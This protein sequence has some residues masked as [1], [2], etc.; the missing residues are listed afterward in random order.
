MPD[1]IHTAEYEQGTG[2]NKI[3]VRVYFDLENKEYKVKDLEGLDL[4]IENYEEEKMT[5]FITLFTAI[6]AAGDLKF[7]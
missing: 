4:R 1:I 3:S 6:K 5:N 2:D 7:A